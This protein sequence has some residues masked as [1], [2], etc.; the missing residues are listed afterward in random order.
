MESIV[1]HRVGVM[2]ASNKTASLPYREGHNF[3]H[4]PWNP[5]PPCRRRREQRRG[6]MGG[7]TSTAP[8]AEFQDLAPIV[9]G[10]PFPPLPTPKS[11]TGTFRLFSHYC[12][13]PCS[14][15]EGRWRN[16]SRGRASPAPA[17]GVRP[18]PGAAG[19]EKRHPGGLLPPDAGHAG[20]PPAPAG[21]FLTVATLAGG[22]ARPAHPL[23]PCAA[24]SAW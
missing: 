18:H 14:R 4:V 9:S 16:G 7:Q 6:E 1:L 5:I 19:A 22:G 17:A 8:A 2:P 12:M 24:A 3:R 13:P 23:P 21:G 20:P 10:M 15:S 11:L